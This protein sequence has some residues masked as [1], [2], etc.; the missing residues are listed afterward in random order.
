MMIGLARTDD[1]LPLHLVE[2]GAIPDPLPPGCA[3]VVP[4]GPA[5]PAGGPVEQVA[6]ARRLHAVGCACCLARTAVAEAL[7][8]LYLRRARGEVGLFRTVLVALPRAEVEEAFRDVLVS[9]RFRIA[10]AT[11][12]AA[13][14]VVA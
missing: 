8:R 13:S 9:S 11:G 14:D 1:R 4:E 5:K 12:A 3:A 7:N 6:R 2:A 10:P